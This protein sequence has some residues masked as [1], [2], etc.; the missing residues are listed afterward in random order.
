MIIIL[1]KKIVIINDYNGKLKIN[2]IIIV[3]TLLEMNQ[4]PASNIIGRVDM[5]LS[6]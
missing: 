6:K 1:V 4:I 5:Q 3:I 2:I